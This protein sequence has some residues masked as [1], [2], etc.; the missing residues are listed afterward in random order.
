M[1]SRKSVKLTKSQLD[2]VKG[3]QKKSKY[4]RSQTLG[5][6]RASTGFAKNYGLMSLKEKKSIDI[7]YDVSVAGTLLTAPAASWTLLNGIANGTGINGRIGSKITMKSIYLRYNV[8]N[9][10]GITQG[11]A[12]NVPPSVTRVILLY[13]SQWNGQATTPALTDVLLA[14]GDVHAQLELSNRDR[15]KVLMDKLYV[16]GGG[17]RTGAAGS[18]NFNPEGGDKQIYAVKKY[19]KLN[20]ETIFSGVDA[21]QASIKTGAIWLM[22]TC[23]GNPLVAGAPVPARVLGSSRIRFD[24]A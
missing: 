9:N 10:Y 21:T 15:F 13:D 24:D 2:K 17:D 1:S 6:L 18:N 4:A 22:M 23:S 11:P 5:T 16:I 12:L 20:L 8:Y 14:P 19:K 3:A 7:V